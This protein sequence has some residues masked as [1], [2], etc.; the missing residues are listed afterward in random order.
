MSLGLMEVAGG[1]EVCG[2]LLLPR[3]A[4]SEQAHARSVDVGSGECRRLIVIVS[5]IW[6]IMGLCYWP[7]IS[8]CLACFLARWND[9]LAGWLCC[10]GVGRWMMES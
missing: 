6:F 2:F 8:G 5:K 4:D 1:K 10:S 7:A 3:V 9:W